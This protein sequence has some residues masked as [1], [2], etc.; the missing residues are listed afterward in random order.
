MTART[1]SSTPSASGGAPGESAGG[2]AAGSRKTPKL[3]KLPPK[4]LVLRHRPEGEIQREILEHLGVER[5]GPD[6]KPSGV[7]VSRKNDG[8]FWRQ[9]CG[10]ARRG[11]AFVRFAP[12]GT[13]DILGCVAGAFIALEIKREGEDQNPAQVAWQRMVED[14]GGIY[15]VVRSVSEALAVVEEVRNA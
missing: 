15:R 6:G 3:P 11:K 2:V 1:S 14:S 13:A 12:P 8:M 5:R 10:S 9:N 7:F 4:V